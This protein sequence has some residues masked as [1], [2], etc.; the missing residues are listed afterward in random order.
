MGPGPTNADPGAGG[1][2]GASP[3]H[4][5]SGRGTQRQTGTQTTTGTYPFRSEDFPLFIDAKSIRA[6]HRTRRRLPGSDHNPAVASRHC[7]ACRYQALW[8]LVAYG[9]RARNRGWTEE[10]ARADLATKPGTFDSMAKEGRRREA[11][12]AGDMARPYDAAFGRRYLCALQ[13]AQ[14]RSGLSV[15]VR[16]AQELLGFVI[17]AVGDQRGAVEPGAMVPWSRI[18]QRLADGPFPLPDGLRVD[19]VWTEIVAACDAYPPAARLLEAHVFRR[20]ANG[21]R[22]ALATSPGDDTT[23]LAVGRVVD[24]ERQAGTV[25]EEDGLTVAIAGQ[26]VTQNT[27]D[28][29]VA[30]ELTRQLVVDRFGVDALATIAAADLTLVAGDALRIARHDRVL[31]D[32]A[33]ELADQDLR[34]RAS[35]RSLVARR[36][37][38]GGVRPPYDQA[39]EIG[40]VAYR[41]WLERRAGEALR[42]AQ[43]L[44]LAPLQSNGARAI[45][46]PGSSS[47]WSRR[48]EPAARA[49]VAV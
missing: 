13:R 41:A 8:A 28:I 30:R 6:D 1:G 34:D 26:L 21:S 45:T 19:D 5:L 18:A 11:A 22:Q 39:A 42:L 3:A 24:D 35:A 49:A 7:A 36:F 12:A 9:G 23:G 10:Q 40:R 29:A 14:S 25:A 4:P 43:S 17:Q 33:Y 27:D 15:S 46:A 38:E 32:V 44:R 16:A 48:R 37:Q 20:S 31:R 2:P 47:A